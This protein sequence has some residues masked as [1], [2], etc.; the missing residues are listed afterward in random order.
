[1]I[2]ILSRIAAATLFSFT[3]LAAHAVDN[4]TSLAGATVVTPE[5]A[6]DL[7]SKG[8]V[9]IDARSAAEYAEGH[10]DGAINVPYKEKSEKKPDFDAAADSVDL[11]KLPGNKAQPIVTYCN[12]HDCWKS[13]K[14]SIAAM[15]AG[16][17]KV[18]WLRDGLPGWKAK[19][20]PVK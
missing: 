15:K 5:Q 20:L 18:N 14:L 7:Q 10:I 6:R 12:G 19:G 8:A 1:M 11:G 16:H 13:Y 2:R 3:A 9:V 4:P 17:T